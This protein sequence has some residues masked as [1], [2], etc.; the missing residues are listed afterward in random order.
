M[1]LPLTKKFQSITNK[2]PP[3]VTLALIVLAWD[4]ICNREL[5]SP[6]MLPSPQATLRIFV[7]DFPI[8]MRHAKTTLTEAFIGLGIG[9]ALA[10]VSAALMDRF[11]V[12]Y[13]ALYPILVITQT[14]P[15][16]ALA[17]ILILWLGYEMEP[18]IALVVLTTFFPIAVSLLDGYRGVDEDEI[19]LLRSLGANRPQVFFT[20]KFPAA[21]GNFFSGLKISASY[22]VVGAVISEWIGGFEGLGVYITRVRKAYAF[23]KMFAVILLIIA[24]SLLL[25]LLVSVLR[26]LVMPWERKSKTK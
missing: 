18:K 19:R 14:I 7:K 25:M 3:V 20:I 1:C 2:I 26:Y 15:T 8:L 6:T 22:A 11:K 13:R 23:D 21:L 16:V 5:V 10:F 12:L 4:L 9:I 24:I 17:P